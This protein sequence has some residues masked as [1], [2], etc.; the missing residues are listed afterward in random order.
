[1]EVTLFQLP[2]RMQLRGQCGV[3]VEGCVCVHPFKCV[4]RVEMTKPYLVVNDSKMK[5]MSMRN[6]FK[7]SEKFNNSR[8]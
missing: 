8:E 2:L 6:W 3:G 4:L 1:M 7:N 5:I